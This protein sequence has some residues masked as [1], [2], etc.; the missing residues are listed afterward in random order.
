[1]HVLC[2]HCGS[3]IAVASRP[4]GTTSISG[5]EARGVHIKG[6]SISFGEGG[7]ISFGPGGGISFGPPAPSEFR[8]FSCGKAA[9]YEA[10]EILED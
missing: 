6:G 10:A 1:M 7:G 5:V 9:S 4:Q 8:C 2:K 3:K